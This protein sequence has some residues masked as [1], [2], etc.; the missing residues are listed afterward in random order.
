MKYKLALF[1]RLCNN[2][3]TKELMEEI[4]MEG[5]RNIVEGTILNDVLD[6]LDSDEQ[7]NDIAVIKNK[8]MEYC[9]GYKNRLQTTIKDNETAQELKVLLRQVYSNKLVIENILHAYDM[10]P[11]DFWWYNN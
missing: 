6:I 4:F 7:I 2:N 10:E 3:F 11:Y 8:C 1:I 5:N 9:N